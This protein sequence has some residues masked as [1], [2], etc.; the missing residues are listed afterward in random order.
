M[1]QFMDSEAA[2]TDEDDQATWQPA[3]QLQCALPGPVCGS[4]PKRDPA[5]VRRRRLQP[6]EKAIFGGV[7]IGADQDPA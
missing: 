2:V 6:F 7:P 5:L 4:A 3:R 1:G